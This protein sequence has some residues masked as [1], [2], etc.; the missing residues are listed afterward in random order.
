MK[1]KDAT[2]RPARAGVSRRDFIKTAGSGAMAMAVVRGASEARAETGDNMTAADEMVEIKLNVNGRDHELLVEP[3]WSLTY[4]LREVLG[5]T[6]AKIGCERGECGSCTVL[7]DGIPRYS[8][9]TL[10][11][12]AEGSRIETAEGLMDG[13]KPGVVQQSFVEND[14]LQCGYCTPGQVMAAEGL[15]RANPAPDFDEIRVGMSGN[16]C[17]CGAYAHIFNSVADAAKRRKG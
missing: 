1:K 4:V 16:L 5:L 14:G 17:R 13:E 7:I 3:R 8:C 11:V 15:L 10:A 6:A 12:E 9:M 2:P